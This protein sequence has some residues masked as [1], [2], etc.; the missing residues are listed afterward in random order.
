MSMDNAQIKLRMLIVFVAV[1]TLILVVPTLL[2]AI[3]QTDSLAA[4]LF[5]YGIAIGVLLLAAVRAGHE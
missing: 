5:I 2:T 4:I 1:L 3:Q